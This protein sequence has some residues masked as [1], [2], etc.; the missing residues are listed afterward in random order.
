MPIGHSRRDVL[1]AGLAMAG[2]AGVLG[3]RRPLADEGPPE[4]TTIRI[5]ASTTLCLAPQYIAEDLLRAEGFTDIRYVESPGG[6]ATDWES[7]DFSLTAAPSIIL[8]GQR[9]PDHGAGRSAR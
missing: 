8:F 6:L 5:A 7:E 2:A 3:A 9:R 1:V 4:T